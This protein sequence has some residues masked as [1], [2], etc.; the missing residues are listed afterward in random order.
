[1]E[2]LCPM[3]IL[4]VDNYDSFTWNLY[5]YLDQMAQEV[6]VL[7]HDEPG[8]LEVTRFDGVVISPGPGLPSD[9]GYTLEVIQRAAVQRPLLGVCLGMQAIAV[10]YGGELLN[11]G[12]VL[13]GRQCATRI[14]CHEDPLFAAIPEQMKTGHYHSWV[15]NPTNLPG[16][17]RP[18]ARDQFGNMMALRHNTMPVYGVQFHPES[19]LTPYGL[20]L[21]ENWTAIVNNHR[22][23]VP[24]EPLKYS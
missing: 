17:L 2:Y 3:R 7:R 10:A 5:H 16:V 22:T 20:R 4:L 23:T 11:L 18:M 13:H 21:I 24:A 8:C 19:V 14:D 1:M 12:Q 6:V 15:V 9:A